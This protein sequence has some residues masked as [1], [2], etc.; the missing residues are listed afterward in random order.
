MVLFFI[1]GVVVLVVF[2]LSFCYEN[3]YMVVIEKKD[4]GNNLWN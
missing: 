3:G 2:S 4:E 1:M